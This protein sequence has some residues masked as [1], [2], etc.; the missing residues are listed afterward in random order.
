M[1]N[2]ILVFD[3][4]SFLFIILEMEFLL[5]FKSVE[6]E[7]KKYLVVTSCMC[8]P[9]I[10]FS[11]ASLVISI[12]LINA[13]IP[14]VINIVLLLASFCIESIVLMKIRKHS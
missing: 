10:L 8:L 11:I 1:E 14:S 3:F 7:K 5:G 6:E 4:F 9:A 13:F 2:L 12:V